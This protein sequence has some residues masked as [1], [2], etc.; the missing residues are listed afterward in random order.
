MDDL[1]GRLGYLSTLP[2]LLVDVE[3]GAE[4]ADARRL[5]FRVYNPDGKA[6]PGRFIL[7]LWLATS[8]AGAP[9]GAGNTVAFTTGTVLQTILAN[10]AYLVLTDANG[11]AALDLTIAG[12]ATRYPR[13]VVLGLSSPERSFAW[14]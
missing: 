11:L 8:S 1:V 6:E 14:A 7:M 10:G 5:T 2:R 12:A 3:A 13:A 4:A 9:S